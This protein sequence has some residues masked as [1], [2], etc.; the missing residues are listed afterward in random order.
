[1]EINFYEY[2]INIGLINKETFS[3]LIL[4]YHNKFSDNNFSENMKDLLVNFLDNLSKEEKNYM[5]IN[6]IKNYL[7]S[8]KTKKF[9]KLKSI[10]FKL[11]EKLLFKKLKYLSK[12]KIQSCMGANGENETIQN[13]K[14]IND[15]INK[16][17]IKI[18]RYRNA[19]VELDSYRTL[20]SESIRIKS[21]KKIKNVSLL[22]NE[23]TTKKYDSTKD[24]VNFNK[25]F[26]KKIEEKPTFRT[27]KEQEE[28][29][30]CTFSPKINNYSNINRNKENSEAISKESNNKRLF[31]IFYKLHNDKLIYL[32]KIKYNKEK[33]EKKLR[34]ENTFRPKIY[35]NNS[36]SKKL[37]KSNQTFE[38][39]QKIYLE[40]KEKNSEK[41]KQELDNNFSEICSFV[42][43]VNTIKNSLSKSRIIKNEP[44]SE[45]KNSEVILDYYS[46]RTGDG[47]IIS[48]HKSPFLRL[49][50]ES[51]NR[52]LRQKSR[53]KEYKYNLKKMANISCKKQLNE[54][55][56]EKLKELYLYDKKR[57]IIKRTKQKVENEEGITFRPDI[58]YNKSLKNITSG[59]YERNEK[60][61]KD[62]QNFIESSIKERDKL[63]NNNL[64]HKDNK[65]IDNFTKEEKD[66]IIKNIVKRL[67]YE[68]G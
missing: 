57:D 50:E 46:S 19:S 16:I 36:F 59:F 65:N 1:M 41:I 3:N 27:L 40:K 29:K 38:E 55:D 2:L 11:E 58:F 18:K 26:N 8:L 43:E 45:M 51:K 54:V 23:S 64:I 24:S 12:W 31:D 35:N 68:G 37:N 25:N 62:K 28:L 48:K 20:K 67:A 9:D 4:E 10:Y 34:E 32:N 66:E 21:K 63:F 44:N 15:T 22:Q 49:Y 56:Y 53:E 60:F 39:R 13:F 5:S 7:E 6:L 52:N 33:Y 17:N 42:P 30:E 61:I 47:T 14:K